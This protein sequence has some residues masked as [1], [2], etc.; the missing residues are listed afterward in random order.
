MKPFF[1]EDVGYHISP[2]EVIKKR[3]VRRSWDSWDRIH[4]RFY[5]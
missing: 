3:R 2:T 1:S 5:F 4:T